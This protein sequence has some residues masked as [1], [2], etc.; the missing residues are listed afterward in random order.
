M[1]KL[2]AAPVTVIIAACKAMVTFT[3]GITNLAEAFEATT[4]VAKD[5]ATTWSKEEAAVNAAKLHDLEK[6][7][8]EAKE[9]GKPFQRQEDDE[10]PL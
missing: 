10:I 2:F 8:K 4:S 9:T 1:F 6:R 7:I 3:Q 5:A